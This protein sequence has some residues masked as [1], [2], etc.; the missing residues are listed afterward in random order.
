MSKISLKLVEEMQL[1]WDYGQGFQPHSIREKQIK[2]NIFIIVQYTI[3]VNV[4]FV[5]KYHKN[6]IKSISI[7]HPLYFD[8]RI[9]NNPL[10]IVWSHLIGLTIT[11][12]FLKWGFSST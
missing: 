3:A 1:S 9:T 6:I 4:P 10:Y 12:W 2:Y 11:G 7:Y 8:C 5:V